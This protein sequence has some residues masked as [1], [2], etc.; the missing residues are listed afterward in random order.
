MPSTI[1][2]S[3]S[4][5]GSGCPSVILKSRCALFAQVQRKRADDS[6]VRRLRN[7]EQLERD[8]VLA[9]RRIAE[10]EAARERDAGH[11][12]V[13]GLLSLR[14]FRAQ[15]EI[16]V[17]RARR[18]GRPLAVALLDVDGFRDLNSHYGHGPGD[19][20]LSE[21]AR[22]LGQNTRGHDVVSRMGNDEF[23]M[24]LPETEVNGALQCFT[25]VL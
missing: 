21:V 12:P 10:L 15:L 1:T 24:L 4:A 5:Q 7:A 19:T 8:L 14:A 16:E 17:D 20:V 3:D 25:R 6:G 9:R 23:S 13:T 2:C 18:H 22:V 11:D